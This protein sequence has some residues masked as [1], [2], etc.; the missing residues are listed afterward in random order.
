MWHRVQST[1]AAYLFVAPFVVTF[2][3][4]GLYPIIKSLLL[5]LYITAGPRAQVFVGFANFAFVL[6]DPDFYQAVRNTVVFA[7]CNLCLQLPLA[8]AVAV[9]LNSQRLKGRNVLRFVFFSPYLMGLVF[10]SILFTLIFAENFGLLN[11]TLDALLGTPQ[12]QH[13]LQR[14]I[15][16]PLRWLVGLQPGET[17]RQVRWLGASTLVMPALVMLSLWLGTGF[18]MIY[19]LAALQAV[20]RDLYDVAQVD[21]ATRWQQ[22]V[23]VTLPGI[24]PVCVFVVILSTIGSL[25]V[26]ELPWLLLRNSAGP[27]QAGLTIVMYLYQNG[28]IVGDLGYASAIGWFLA[29]GIFCFALIQVRLSGAMQQEV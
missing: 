11:V 26:F 5:S 4:F 25:R 20:N 18:N 10:A 7:L 14:L 3:V 28:F 12:T 1:Y 17:W 21:G 29:V 22:F 24:K 23:H 19:F 8:L 6:T 16:L 9:A 27:D 2:A 15:D 13:I